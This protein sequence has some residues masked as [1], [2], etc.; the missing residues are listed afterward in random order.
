MKNQTEEKK[1]SLDK[2]KMPAS[3]DFKPYPAPRK[4]WIHCLSTSNRTSEGFKK[5]KWEGKVVVIKNRTNHSKVQI[6][7][8]QNPFPCVK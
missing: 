1:D 2:L 7:E 5:G 3:K 6:I 8:Q 4:Y